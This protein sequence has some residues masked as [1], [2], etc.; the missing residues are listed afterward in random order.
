MYRKQKSGFDRVPFVQ[1]CEIEHGDAR[2]PAML[3]N[4]SILGA[5]VHSES[6][7]LAGTAIG[8]R[9]ALPDDSTDVVANATVTWVQ[10]AP[11]GGPAGLPTG[12]GLRFTT[13]A[14]EDLRRIASLVARFL[15]E[16]ELQY[17]VGVGMPP[18]GKARIPFVAPCTF[19]SEAA[20]IR[21]TICNLSTLGIF[22]AL[23]RMPRE[24][25]R[26]RLRFPIP[27]LAGQFESEAVVAWRNLEHPK[28]MPALPSGCG[29]RFENLAP[30]DVLVLET[31]VEDYLGSFHSERS[32]A[33]SDAPATV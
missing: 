12:F 8:I 21:G 14:P 4:L 13:V 20:P 19:E 11:A 1:R 32:A 28:R 30:L 29:F 10:L 31:L 7:P 33:S 17:Q 3:C 9:F 26:G 22:A 27:G 2:V 6:P 25:A 24:G 15:S 16:H 5:Y 23:E 18:S